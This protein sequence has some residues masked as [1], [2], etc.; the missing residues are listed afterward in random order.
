VYYQFLAPM[1]VNEYQKQQR[2]IE[3]QQR[4]LD[5]LAHEV[6]ELKALLARAPGR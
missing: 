6:A 3:A 1:L 5:A 2:T 4:E